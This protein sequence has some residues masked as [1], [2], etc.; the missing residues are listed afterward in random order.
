MTKRSPYDLDGEVSL[1]A[2]AQRTRKKK[3]RE[4]AS[5]RDTEPNK[6]WLASVL[7][8]TQQNE[9]PL[10]AEAQRDDIVARAQPSE[11]VPQA[12]ARMSVQV[13][14]QKKMLLPYLDKIEYINCQL[15]QRG[16]LPAQEM[17]LLKP[18]NQA[19]RG[20]NSKPMVKPPSRVLPHALVARNQDEQ[21]AEASAFT[22]VKVST[23]MLQTRYPRFFE[24]VV[25]AGAGKN[26]LPR[27]RGINWLLRT[28]EVIYNALADVLLRKTGGEES[29]PS[30]AK[31]TTPG[32]LAMPFFARRFIHHSLGLAELADQECVDLMYTIELTRELY[33]QVAAFASFLR[34]I[35]DEDTLLFFL[36]VRSH[37]QEELDLDLAAKEKQAHSSGASGSKKYVAANMIELR[38]HPLIPD[39]TKQVLLSNSACE[40]VMHRVF[41]FS[42][43]IRYDG[44]PR[45]AAPMLLAQYIVREPFGNRLQAH[46]SRFVVSAEEFLITLVQL[47]GEVAED[48]LAQF[49]FNDDGESLS[50][51]IRLRDT[52]T[53]D[54]KV[55]KW[56]TLYAEQ[57]RALRNLKIELMKMERSNANNQ[58]RVH[59]RLLQHQIRLQEQEL[60][61]IQKKIADGENL[62]NNVWKEVAAVKSPPKQSMVRGPARVAGDV[63]P[64]KELVSV[65]GRF[66][67]HIGRLQKKHDVAV[68]A[69]MLLAVPWQQQM[70]EL[71]QRMVVRVQRAYRARK[72]SQETK[73]K[74]R[75]KL[76]AQ[77]REREIKLKNQELERKRLEAVREK[78]MERHQQ[79]LKAKKE[80]EEKQKRE[81]DEKQKKLV[82]KAREEEATQRAAAV[83]KKQ[84][85]H[86]MEQWKSVVRRKKNRRK[87]NL[88]FLK[89]KLMKWK[90]HVAQH[91]R[92]A[93]AARTIQ[94]FVRHRKEGTQL[95]KLMKLRAKRA[96]IA[97]KYLSKVQSRMV[98][99]L[100]NH[101]A[102]FTL[103]QQRLRDNFAAIIQ[104]R[105]GHWLH[106]WAAFVDTMKTRKLES[107]IL[108]QRQYRGRV[109]R[110]VFRLQRD[111][112][113]RALTIQR[114]YRGH[115]G[116]VI[117]RKRKEIK[118]VQDRGVRDLLRRVRN[119]EA[120]A[121][122]AMLV[123]FTSW[124]LRIK[125]MTQARRVAAGRALLLAWGAFVAM[126][127]DK[128]AARL[129]LHNGSALVIQRNVR[130]HRC[131]VDFKATR[132]NHR[133]AITIQRV[134]RGFLGRQAAKRRRW[135]MKAALQVQTV[136]RRH[137]AKKYAAAVRTEKILLATFKGDYTTVQRAIA[138]GFWH[139]VDAE[140]NS[141]LHLAAAA[142]HKRLVKLC[143]R[144]S[145]DINR[146][147]AHSQSALHLLLA[148]LP[149]VTAVYDVSD[150]RARDQRVA[151]A[152]YMIE[153]GAWHE[154]PDEEGFT[155]LLMC[156]SLGQSE[157]VD[158]LLNH[159][160]DTEAKT[161]GGSLNATQLAVEGNYSATLKLLLESGGFDTGESG[162]TTELLLHAC[163]GR[164]LVDCVRVLVAH[165]RQRLEV[166]G[167]EAMNSCD[168]EGYTPLIY[169]VSNGHVDVTECLLEADAGPDVKDFFGRSPL[170]FALISDDAATREAL[171]NLLIQYD[172]DVN[173]KDTDG[174]APLHVS[175]VEDDR[176]ACTH[177]L[178]TSGASISA[179]ALGNH[180]THIAARNGAVNTLKLLVDYG[181]DM[182]LKNYEGK[183]PLGMARM[184]DQ[185]AVVEFVA[186][187]FAQESAVKKEVGGPELQPGE[188]DDESNQEEHDRPQ[189]QQI[190]SQVQSAVEAAGQDDNLQTDRTPAEWTAA[191]S[192]AYC[193]GSIAEWTQ[194]VDAS[195]EVPFYYSVMPSGEHTYTWESPVEFD[196]AMGELWEVVRGPSITP[197][198]ALLD[199]EEE[200]DPTSTRKAADSRFYLYHNRVTDELT[201][202]IPPINFALLQDVVQ[203]SKR[204]KLLR[205]RVRKV[206]ADEL[207]ASAM[208]YMRFFRGFEAESA[209]IRKEMRAAIKIQRHFRARRTHLLVKALLHQ[210]R[211][212]VH[213]QRAFRGRK[214]RREAETRRKQQIEVVKIQAACRGHLTRKRE[215]RGRRAQRQLHL[216]RRLAARDIQRTFRGFTGRKLGY[217]E[218]VVQRLGPKG[219]FDWEAL[220]KRA[221]IVRRFK[222]WDEMEARADFPGVLFYCH[223]VTRA[224][225]WQQPPLWSEH[226]LQVLENRRQLG[227]W[228]YTEQMQQAAQSVQTL[229]RARVARISFQMVIRSVRLMR[230][231][232]QEYLEDPTN[233]VKMGNYVLYLHTITHDYDRAR[234][235]YGRLMRVMAQR[236]PDI[237]FVLL[238]Y[239]IFL[240][241]TQEE[242]TTL[243]EEMVVRGKMAD[244]TLV[245]YK[246]AF[247][248]FF[249]QAVLQNPHDAEAHVNYAACVQWLYEQYDEATNHY[250]QALALA[251]QRKGTM[252]MFQNLLDRRRRIERAKLTPR[253]RRAFT[254]TEDAG[255]EEQ[256]DAFA[257]FRR[258]QAKQAEEDDRVR[259]MALQAEQEAVDRVAAA[260]KIQTRYRR[261]NA[262]RKVTRLR[263][264]YK[265]AAAK[266]EEAQQQALYDSITAAFEEILSSSSKKTNKRDLAVVLSLPVVQLN[267]LFIALKME[268]TDA[269]LNAV[270]TKFRKDHPKLKQVNV[271]DICRF[272]QAQ[273]LL[274][275]RLPS[276][277]AALAPKSS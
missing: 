70:E 187:Y 272:V 173:V 260:R 227:R 101:W 20:A 65:L 45:I 224:C 74:A 137:K 203:N 185:P 132:R 183:T 165:F 232:E 141:I 237:P 39:G 138:N 233:L 102:A 142:G 184:N 188:E 170:H 217:R 94:H 16:L 198:V 131:Q 44:A 196:A 181:G 178:L 202:S 174:D 192:E 116:R 66:E 262:T 246:V 61:H 208:E 85:C 242:D 189:E 151:L 140:G 22:P 114:R 236:G 213:L 134:C 234:P 176:L 210:N 248:G 252:D 221:S 62:V 10:E 36:F 191:V 229:W 64:S 18:D 93:R 89:F 193:M 53:L 12:Q 105:E 175:C 81:L 7:H 235:L 113:R 121:C 139:V 57:E 8:P 30:G 69:S 42:R 25:Q 163:A 275:E 86:V 52:I 9:P 3:K 75:D 257:R 159:G 158:M 11:R 211:C 190:G 215:A 243:V 96:K 154:A 152:E 125:K 266:A 133:A 26:L 241:A 50:S 277:F 110:H 67:A 58:F 126:R 55:D 274:Q 59:M 48:I 247:L 200:E 24:A 239:G 2:G 40:C 148:N 80:Q 108:I 79:R 180:P 118:S 120:G 259:R 212:A 123:R 261:R 84:L 117:A 205:A 106:R 161:S 41:E 238:S 230:T 51:L 98:N 268:F 49:K 95:R 68:K 160:A 73:Q 37:L 168:S 216:T 155:P 60:Q 150:V 273:P 169:A 28:I 82:Q 264:E 129:R 147:N 88:L 222:V 254:Q 107:A 29:T 219:Y 256:F 218:T 47:F 146:V 171:V 115:R 207:S 195:T 250:L 153:H 92:M 63:L 206:S 251:P 6:A 267:A 122:F 136:W 186:A 78:D 127:K 109:A 245:K 35:F 76:S 199:G 228:G 201:S 99:R 17:P 255:V 164:G 209:Q 1:A 270:S 240:Y 56:V 46:E 253:S 13:L 179:N 90:L 231:C 145:F 263:L 162:R 54:S 128:R 104:K 194:Y 135:E 23:R 271:M 103:E 265:I 34:E 244:P 43:R 19:G 149:P 112:H 124:E 204:M 214:A 83:T 111:R 4:S 31:P 249:R 5:D 226:D 220:R 144:N 143:L 223:Q 72:R 258:W 182:N 177:L 38:N 276:V 269:Q 172:A 166:F 167:Y 27:E 77:I 100:F 91:K 225:S 157:A 119:R 130:R 197:A 87:A 71:K 15:R 32:W 156:A 14:E 33:P 97:T 21:D